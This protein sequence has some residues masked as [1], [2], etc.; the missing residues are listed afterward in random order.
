MDYASTADPG[1]DADPFSDKEDDPVPLAS[2]TTSLAVSAT[3]TT[4]TPGPTGHGSPS[5]V[6]AG[7]Q[8]CQSMS[9]RC[10]I[11]DGRVVPNG[12]V[13]GSDPPTTGYQ[14][15]P[16]IARR[17]VE[18]CCS[19]DSLIG[20]R[21]PPECEVIRLTADDDLTTPVGIKKA[22]DAVTAPGMPT[23]LFGSLPCTGGSP[24][25]HMNW[26]RGAATRT[27][28]RKHWRLFRCL[29]LGFRQVADAC[30]ANGGRIAIEWPKS[31]AYWRHRNVRSCLKRWGCAAH[32]LDGC[33]YGLVS[34][35]AGTRGIPILKPW[36]ISSNAEG[37]THVAR[38]CDRTHEHVRIQGCLLY[39]SPSPR[40][41]EESRMPSS[42]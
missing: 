18:F 37:F 38:K 35:T 4:T 26:Y 7:I 22:M 33:M 10:S 13:G 28:I 8:S 29:W 1:S 25:Q 23:L 19:S 14:A 15:T 9:V 11:P 41:V 39:T 16:R 36:T 31:C 21:A 24:Y 20:S 27:K 40:D 12:E 17:I 6:C 34:Q 3:A 42:A 30:I 2:P 32:H 5:C